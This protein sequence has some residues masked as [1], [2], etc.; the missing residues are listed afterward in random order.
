MFWDLSQGLEV[1]C[2]TSVNTLYTVHRYNLRFGFLEKDPKLVT[3][4]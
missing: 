4:R 1:Q 3:F 2:V